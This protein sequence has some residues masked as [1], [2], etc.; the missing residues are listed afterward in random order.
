MHTDC[1]PEKLRNMKTRHYMKSL[2][3]VLGAAAAMLL[4]LTGCQKEFELDLPLAVSSRNL[5]GKPG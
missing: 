4:A 1:N 3:C 5:S 2:A